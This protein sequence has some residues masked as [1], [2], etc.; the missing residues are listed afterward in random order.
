MVIFASNSFKY[1]ANRVLHIIH[2]KEIKNPEVSQAI[3]DVT[4]NAEQIIHIGEHMLTQPR[5]DYFDTVVLHTCSYAN[6]KDYLLKLKHGTTI[7]RLRKLIKSEEKRLIILG[8]ALELVSTKVNIIPFNTRSVFGT[9][10]PGIDHNLMDLATPGLGLFH[11]KLDF[12]LTTR[13]ESKEYERLIK[14]IST[15]GVIIYLLSN[16]AIFESDGK[17]KQG[18]VYILKGSHFTK[19]A[20]VDIGLIDEDKAEAIKERDIDLMPD[21]VNEVTDLGGASPKASDMDL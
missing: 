11:Q 17:V 13:I 5:F 3:A 19:L 16:T 18:E 14:G 1:H 9:I 2:P 20:H 15:K 4:A 8:A 10:K 6:I 12:N 7:S 21:S